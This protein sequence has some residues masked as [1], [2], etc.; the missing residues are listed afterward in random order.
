MEVKAYS[1]QYALI[2]RKAQELQLKVENL[3][4]E[5]GILLQENYEL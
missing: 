5:K 1:E 2:E 3:E 4:S